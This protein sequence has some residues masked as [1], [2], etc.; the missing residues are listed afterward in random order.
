[1]TIIPRGIILLDGADGSGKSTLAK[2]LRAQVELRGGTAAIAHYP[3]IEGSNCWNVQSEGLLEHLWE[4]FTDKPKVIIVDR[5]FPSEGIYGDVYREGSTM[6]VIAR[7]L[8]R[9]LYRFCAARVICA[10]PVNYVKETHARLKTEREEAFVS[11]ADVVA[12]RYLDLWHGAT[13]CEVGPYFKKYTKLEYTEQLCLQGGVKNRR[14]WLHYDVTRDGGDIAGYASYILAYLSIAQRQGVEELL[15]PA[16]HSF[17]GSCNSE[18]LLVSDKLAGPN[19]LS[20]PFYS[21]TGSSLYL[22]EVLQKLEV[23]ESKVSLIN[24]NDEIFPETFKL[25]APGKK[26]IVMGREAEKTL[27]RQ[28]LEFNAVVAH[29]QHARQFSSKTGAWVKQLRKAFG[30]LAGVKQ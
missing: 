16:L 1:M 28:K 24:A 15:D 11:S 7:H 22:A 26:V 3:L 8:D 10:P 12:Q 30:G 17:T 19:K 9:L 23:D 27:V 18:V 25:L 13:E 2:V 29:P 5:F 4:A 6:P 14:G 21:S 20:V